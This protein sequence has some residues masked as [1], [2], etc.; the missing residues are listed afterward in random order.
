MK[1][2][3]KKPFSLA[4]HHKSPPP[5]TPEGYFEN[6]PAQVWQKIKARQLV[7][8]QQP[9][10][11]KV[12]TINWSVFTAVAAAV[13]LLLV[14]TWS[15]WPS[16]TKSHTANAQPH[17]ISAENLLAS[18][19]SQEVLDYL[20]DEATIYSTE[21]QMQ[22]EEAFTKARLSLATVPDVQIDETI[23]LE[24]ASPDELEEALYTL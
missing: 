16:D 7:V 12:Q 19:S 23:L 9:P 13:V 15:V 2:Q 5:E 14:A 22:V 20:Q 17:E 11:A 1:N 18:I 10:K 8:E 24:H 4:H 6:L 21:N 3:S